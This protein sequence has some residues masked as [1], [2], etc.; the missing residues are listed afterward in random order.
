MFPS[1]QFPAIREF[2]RDLKKARHVRRTFASVATGFPAIPTPR[3][4][5]GSGNNRELFIRV[6][7]FVL[8]G[9]PARCCGER[10]RMTNSAPVMLKRAQNPCTE[11]RTTSVVNLI[12]V[13][14]SESAR[15]NLVCEGRRFGNTE[16]L[17]EPFSVM[18]TRFVVNGPKSRLGR[19]YL[20]RN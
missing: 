5:T 9:S 3:E 8:L 4:W 6:R 2:N 10:L 16:D 17:Y 18:R 13:I 19:D 1:A 20:G 15:R 14:G 12:F 11:A 7:P